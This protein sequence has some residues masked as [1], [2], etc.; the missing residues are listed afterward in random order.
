[1]RLMML[2]TEVSSI[3]TGVGAQLHKRCRTALSLAGVIQVMAGTAA[4]C[5][6]DL[7]T[8]PLYLHLRLHLVPFVAMALLQCGV[9]SFALS[10]MI[11]TA[12]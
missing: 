10:L 3:F 6:L 12:S 11:L 2:L 8:S 5:L 4:Q 7:G 9:I 1:M